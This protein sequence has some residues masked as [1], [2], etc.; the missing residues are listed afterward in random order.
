MKP[1]TSRQFGTVVDTFKTECPAEAWTDLLL[2]YAVLREK[3]PLCG[4]LI[5]KKLRN[6]DG[7]W[8]LLGHADNNQP[9]L[10]FYF[11]TEAHEIA[12]V[13]AFMKQGNNQYRRAIDLAQRRRR[14]IERGERPIN[15]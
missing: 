3:G 1:W 13:H 2:R 14:L 11:R 7:I 10:L 12:F 4:G 15:V 5:A 6:G 9:R 8:E